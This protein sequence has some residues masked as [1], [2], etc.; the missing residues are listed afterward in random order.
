[1]GPGWPARRYRQKDQE[2]GQGL[3]PT[4]KTARISGVP[5]CQSAH[6]TQTQEDKMTDEKQTENDKR[7]SIAKIY[8]KDFSFES[9]QSPAIFKSGDWSPQTN[10]NLR[11]GHTAVDENLHEVVLT[12][13][14]DAK[15]GDNTIFLVELQQAGLF[16]IAGYENEE[17]AAI[18]GSF[19]PNMLFPYARESIA[20]IIQKGGFP[21]FILQPINFDALYTQA[22]QQKATSE[23]SAVDGTH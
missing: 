12:I 2:Q 23:A 9:P 20:G 4:L 11:S 21:E 10:L 6:A 7:L 13:T 19:C 5:T 18:I 3:R 14:V 1:M 8:V 15:E 22:Q 16:D 17:L